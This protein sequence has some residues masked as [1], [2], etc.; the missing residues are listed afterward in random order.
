LSSHTYARLPLSA[1]DSA[2]EVVFTDPRRVTVGPPSIVWGRTNECVLVA[3]LGGPTTLRP[4]VAIRWFEG[5]GLAAPVS[6][7]PQAPAV[8]KTA[9]RNSRLNLIVIFCNPEE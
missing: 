8:H 9:T 1:K 4:P 6:D 2:G 7:C 3:A 5:A